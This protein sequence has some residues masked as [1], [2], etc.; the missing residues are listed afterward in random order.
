LSN[1][2]NHRRW[3]R[4][5]VGHWRGQSFIFST[6]IGQSS[7]LDELNLQTGGNRWFFRQHGPGG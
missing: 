6:G 4:V 2:N 1:K 5:L 3:T 7:N